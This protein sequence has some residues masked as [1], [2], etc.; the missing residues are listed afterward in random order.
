MSKKEIKV[1]KDK[2]ENIM[3]ISVSE[4]NCYFGNWKDE[5][6]NLI[7]KK[8]VVVNT[9]RHRVVGAF[10]FIDVPDLKDMKKVCPVC[11]G[12][13]KVNSFRSI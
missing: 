11:D 6:K 5:I 10:Q 12:K 2:Q 4:A 8:I 13:G 9:K 3:V 1:T 7:G